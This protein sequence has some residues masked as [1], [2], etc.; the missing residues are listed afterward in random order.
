MLGGSAGTLLHYVISD[1]KKKNTG[2]HKRL[3]ESKRLVE[4]EQTHT[5]GGSAR[6]ERNTTEVCAVETR[7][8]KC[9]SCEGG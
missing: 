5:S 3:H 9:F 6:E 2:I 8:Y 7:L 1:I 4:S